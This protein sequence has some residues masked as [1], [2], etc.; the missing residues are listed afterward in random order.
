MRKYLVCL[1]VVISL[2]MAF[3][4]NADRRRPVRTGATEPTYATPAMCMSVLGPDEF[5]K[6][7]VPFV[8][9]FTAQNGMTLTGYYLVN[10]ERGRVAIP[11]AV[12]TFT[13]AE[14]G[15]YIGGQ[16]LRTAAGDS[17]TLPDYVIG[18]EI[19]F[20]GNFQTISM[21]ELRSDKSRPSPLVD[22]YPDGRLFLKQGYSV[23]PVAGLNGVQHPIVNGWII[24]EVSFLGRSDVPVTICSEF[25]RSKCQTQIVDIPDLSTTQNK[26]FREV[27]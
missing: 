3:S 4:M 18:L 22:V 23:P 27:E 10:D 19:E 26:L 24:P 11:G 7:M 15:W 21:Y 5:N 9:W 20:T 2:L 25:P 13:E 17:A 6:F 8:T 14:A 1:I 12:H 16:L